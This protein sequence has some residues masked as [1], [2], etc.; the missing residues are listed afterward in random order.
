MALGKASRTQI[1]QAEMKTLTTLVAEAADISDLTGL[2][3]ANNLRE[4]DLNYNPITDLSPLA[5]STNLTSLDVTCRVLADISPLSGLTQLTRLNL[6]NNKITEFSSLSG[7]TNLKWLNIAR[8]PI[9]DIS[10]LAGLTNLNYLNLRDN[11]LTDISPLAG[12]TNLREWLDLAGNNLTD[13]SPL[14]GLTNL[15]YLDLRDNSLTDI[16]ALSDLTNLRSLYI[17]FNNI[18]DISP[19]SSLTSLFH[20]YFGANKLTSMSPLSGMIQLRQL[21]LGNNKITNISVLSGLTRLTDVNLGFNNITEVPSLSGLTQLRRL[22]LGFNNITDISSL[23]GLTSRLYLDLRAN[24]LSL[25]SINDH[26]P[27]LENSGVVVLFDSFHEGDF[28]IELVFLGHFPESQKEVIQYA[29]RRWMSVI[30]E[31]LPDYTLTQGWSGTCGDQS[32][33][34]PS[35]ERIDDLRIYAIGDNEHYAL[36][37]GG[38]RL[39]RETTH[40]PVVGCMAF[41]LN[42]RTNLLDTGLHEIGHVLGFGTIWGELGLLQDR[43]GDTHFNGPLA[44]AA[45]D[46]AGGRDYAGAKVPVGQDGD[47][48]RSGVPMLFHHRELMLP[49]WGEL[50]GAITVQSLADLGYGVDVT[51]ADPYILPGAASK[52]VVKDAVSAPSILGDDRTWQFEGAERILGRRVT[53]DLPDNQRTW[54]GGSPSHAEPDLTC[55]AGQMN[56]PIYVVDP[57]GRI[58]RTIN[59]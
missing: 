5:G 42:R 27:A 52:A 53:F 28:D 18:T 25:S 4:L 2:E 55:G 13:I 23:L 32:I 17:G 8:N 22:D 45:F 33:A 16:S 41:N 39:S 59:R 54:G 58:V 14:A 36:G 51:Q 12:L 19:L 10:P 20:L 3:Y 7:L 30:V 6:G 50:L 47:H 38:P 46:D 24:P 26:I 48:W 9:T 11:S 1:T 31:D 57:Q 35:G 37:W 15:A 43:E 56:E 49:A 34:I 21:N 44:V 29:A 40:L